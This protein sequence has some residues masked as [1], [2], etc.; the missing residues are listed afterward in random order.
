MNRHLIWIYILVIQLYCVTSRSV[1]DA[2][3]NNTTGH[4]YPYNSGSS[5]NENNDEK[6]ISVRITSS[7][8]IGRGNGKPTQRAHNGEPKKEHKEVSENEDEN[9]QITDLPLNLKGANIEFLK[10]LNAKKEEQGH[11]QSAALRYPDND[12]RITHETKNDRVNINEG[13]IP[14]GS[15][16]SQHDFS[17]HSFRSKPISILDDALK[18]ADTRLN[19][20]KTDSETF[21]DSKPATDNAY[22][23]T[24]YDESEFN[25]EDKNSFSQLDY[26]ETK[27]IEDSIA[28]SSIKS[29]LKIA[30]KHSEDYENIE[31]VPLARSIEHSPSSKNYIQGLINKPPSERESS[32]RVTTVSF[33]IVHDAPKIP[34]FNDPSQPYPS[35]S[36][37]DQ[38]F[39]ESPTI[40][41]RPAQIYSEPAKIYSV[42]AKIYSEPA[43]IYSEPAKIYSEPAKIYSVPAKFYSEPASLHLKASVPTNYSPWHQQPAP[44]STT[45]NTTPETTIPIPDSSQSPPA[46]H[47]EETNY[48][49]DEKDSAI[50]DGRSDAEES[51]TE[52]CKQDN[53]KVGYVVKGRQF[54]KY[55]VEERTSDGFIVGEYGVVRNEDGAL[56]GVRYTAD[57]E[58]SPRLIYDALMKFLQLK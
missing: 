25:G 10:Q 6:V 31:N 2:G 19:P 8:A 58:A 28:E 35:Q 30:N 1:Q 46:P 14:S 5:S 51:T 9:E 57:S 49:V 47:Q 41:S 32:T 7:V 56:R 12:G 22:L 37:Q 45:L 3:N 44:S 43:K 13:D 26:K 40:Y 17:Y 52:K 20:N 21:T 53:C 39:Y 27:E 50:T 18:L 24:L 55:R 33:N 38:K 15:K 16:I 29:V 34:S 4:V 23:S 36:F 11:L 42:P 48:E 54:N